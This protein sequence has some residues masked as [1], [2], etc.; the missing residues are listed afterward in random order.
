[1]IWDVI[2]WNIVLLAASLSISVIECKQVL[3]H[4]YCLAHLYICPEGVLW[5]NS[6]L[7]VDTILGGAWGQLRM[8]VLDGVHIP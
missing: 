6:W 8:G 7:D 5:Q 2:Q 3:I 1:M 4:A